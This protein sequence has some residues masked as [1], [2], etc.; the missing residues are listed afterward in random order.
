MKDET[1][2]WVFKGYPRCPVCR[3][4]MAIE[5]VGESSWKMTCALNGEGHTCVMLVC[6][7]GYAQ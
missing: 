3:S 7:E 1:D 4:E 2:G 6:D 5:K